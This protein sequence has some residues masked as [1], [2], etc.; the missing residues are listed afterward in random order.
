MSLLKSMLN[1]LDKEHSIILTEDIGLIGNSD[2]KVDETFGEL[3]MIGDLYPDIK[4]G[5]MFT[6][7]T[8]DAV[9]L[10]EEYVD[11][12]GIIY[13][14]NGDIGYIFKLKDY[15]VEDYTWTIL[16]KDLID[17]KPAL[18]YY[19]N[20][21]IQTNCYELKD[22]YVYSKDLDCCINKNRLTRLDINNVAYAPKTLSF[23][24]SIYSFS[25]YKKI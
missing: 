17:S 4:L 1:I 2:Y 12:S 3:R 16:G 14:N 11:L 8:S 6:V 21:V 5:D 10:I 13:E 20:G 9:V 23:E 18:I 7:V 15:S 25:E 24:N 22:K 19:K